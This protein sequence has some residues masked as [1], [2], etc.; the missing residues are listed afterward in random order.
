MKKVFQNKKHTEKIFTLL[1]LVIGVLLFL[2][3]GQY[4]TRFDMTE[5]KVYTITDV[6][7]TVIRGLEDPVTIQYYVSGR[8]RREIPEVQTLIDLLEEMQRI[9]PNQLRVQILDP[10]D[11]TPQRPEDLGIQ[12]QQ[13]QVVEANQQSIA[14]VYTGLAITY[15]DDFIS[16]PVIIDPSTLEYEV[17][18]SIQDLTSDSTRVLGVL[19]GDVASQQNHQIFL[20]QMGGFAE[21]RQIPRG[22]EI[23][24]DVQALFVIGQRD[25]TLEDTFYLD[26]YLMQ[27]RPAVFAW[28]Y[29]QVD[30]QSGL[31]PQEGVSTPAIELAQSYG[32]QILPQWVMDSQ[33][34]P[35]PIQQTQG[36]VVFNTMQNYPLWPRIGRSGADPDHPLTRRF[37]GLDLFWASPV[38]FNVSVNPRLT[39]SF[40][41]RSTFRATAMNPPLQVDPNIQIPG[42]PGPPQGFA[43]GMTLEGEMVSAF[44][45]N[46][47][48][49]FLDWT[50]LDSSV[51]PVRLAVIGDQEVFSD[52]IQIH[53]SLYNLQFAQNLYDW[54]VGDEAMMGIRTR[55]MGTRTLDSIENPEE[56]LSRAQ[57]ARTWGILSGP[58][59]FGIIALWRFA[60]RKKFVRGLA[61]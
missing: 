31:V 20:S 46:P 32:I 27:G 49:A 7:R 56:K 50:P 28:D 25:L 11:D 36:R 47:P 53:R 41:L 17:V 51:S 5:N 3:S 21:I 26:Q 59:F 33:N 38:D 39:P 43:L 30:L 35:I 55:Q 52:L 19:F 18:K 1:P 57:S 9:S 15:R 34:Q 23:P 2:L 29:H 8:L 12:P 61:Q 22:Q 45:Q 37:E 24:A 40:P 16:I 54:L 6:T 14:T 10:D 44:S 42:N 58:L 48:D 60:Q 4:Y 13:Y